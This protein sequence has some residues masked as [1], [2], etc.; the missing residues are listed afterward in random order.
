MA[1]GEPEHVTKLL[2]GH[3]DLQF[4]SGANQVYYPDTESM[5]N[6]FTGGFGP[7]RALVE[8]LEGPALAAYREDFFALHD[9]YITPAG[10]HFKRDSLVVMGTRK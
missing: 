9:K 3:F 1:W 2:G 7:V 4:E 10:L 5:W 8:R 6:L